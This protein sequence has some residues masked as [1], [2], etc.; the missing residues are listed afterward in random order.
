LSPNGPERG[1]RAR[2]TESECALLKRIY[3][4]G[5]EPLSITVEGDLA[6]YVALL[7]TC[8][9]EAFGTVMPALDTNIFTMWNAA[10]P[11][12]RDVLRLKGDVV[13]CPRLGTRYPTAA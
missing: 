12:L 2:L 13:V 7:H 6:A 11:E 5:P 1:K 4:T 9:V 8:G 3:D 10:G